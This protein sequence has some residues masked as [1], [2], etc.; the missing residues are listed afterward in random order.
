[1]KAL[2]RAHD[3]SRRIAKSDFPTF[4][5]PEDDDEEEEELSD[6]DEDVEESSSEDGG[7]DER[8]GANGGSAVTKKRRGG[9][10][11]SGG[12]SSGTVGKALKKKR[13]SI[14]AA[15]RRVLVFAS[16][17]IPHRLRHLLSDIRTLLP[18]HKKDVKFDGRK[19]HLFEI[20]Q[21]CEM[22]SCASCIFLESRK[23]KDFF[24]WMSKT[25]HGPSVKF[26]LMNVHTMDELRLTGNAL[27]GSRPIL[28]FDASFDDD[29]APQLQ[30]VR[31]MLTQVYSTP[32]RH[33]KSKPFVDR[34][35]AFYWLDGKVWFRHFQIVDAARD[36]AHATRGAKHAVKSQGQPGARRRRAVDPESMNPAQVAAQVALAEAAAAAAEGDESEQKRDLRKKKYEQAEAAAT[37]NLVAASVAEAAAAIAPPSIAGD[38][39]DHGTTTLVE[40]G[41]RFV[42]QVSVLLCTVTFYANLAHSLTRSP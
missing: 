5:A 8:V 22:K 2:Q 12:S 30:L 16:R 33:P 17:G 25:P 39:D 32:R 14:P 42:L 31:E 40:I 20:N 13:M 18:H 4:D 19:D 28:H 23:S 10:V 27:K 29:A 15:E 7:D 35:L 21:I 6:Y 11:A 26:E 34:V 41:P 24:L 3:E 1:M 37:E 38:A 36:D 9:A